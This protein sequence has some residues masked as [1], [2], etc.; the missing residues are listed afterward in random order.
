VKKKIL[1]KT[2]ARLEKS[3]AAGTA[4]SAMRLGDEVND[5]G[6][7]SWQRKYIHL[8]FKT[9]RLDL[10]PKHLLLNGYR[11][12]FPRVNRPRCEVDYSL[13]SNCPGSK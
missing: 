12:S 1:D 7:E 3:P 9:S 4:W 2:C 5:P 13:P 10:G 6:F 8:L 11:G